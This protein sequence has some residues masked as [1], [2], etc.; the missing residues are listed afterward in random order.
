MQERDRLID[1]YG[2][3][4]DGNPDPKQKLYVVLPNIMMAYIDNIRLRS[5]KYPEMVSLVSSAELNPESKKFYGFGEEGLMRSKDKLQ[6]QAADGLI[7]T[8]PLISYDEVNNRI[9]A[10]EPKSKQGIEMYQMLSE[11]MG[12]KKMCAIEVDH[13]TESYGCLIVSENERGV[14]DGFGRIF[15]SGD[16]NPCNNILNYCQK[17]TLLIHEATFEDSL[18]ED[19]KWK[20]HTTIGQAIEIGKKCGVWRTVLTHFSPR[21]QKIAEISERNFETKTMVAFD[22]MRVKL[23]QFEWAYS[24]LDIY[25]KLFKNDEQEDKSSATQ[26][27][28][29]QQQMGG[30][31]KRQFKKE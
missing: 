27:G 18:T 10:M 5:L 24:M 4:C 15:Y 21:Y 28:K 26:G 7:D 11:V 20:K 16:T 9:E 8:C 22:H 25:A 13:C 12:V 17:V 2:L 29:K 23:S 30:G 31:S 3:D 1:T 19:A 14:S 6:Q